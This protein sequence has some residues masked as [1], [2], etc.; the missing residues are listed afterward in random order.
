MDEVDV[1]PVED[2]TAAAADEVDKDAK[3][4][5]KEQAEDH[6]DWPV[7]KGVGEGDEPDQGKE[8]AESR[9]D[10]SVDEAPLREM[11]APGV[12]QVLT[13]DTGD[14]GSK[15]ELCAAENQTDNAIDGHCEMSKMNSM[16]IQKRVLKAM[17]K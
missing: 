14:D 8:D 13:V 16:E 6:V 10:F 5:P 4:D 15:D 7:R 3:R 17:Y 9:H 11:G 12:V 2:V 1:V